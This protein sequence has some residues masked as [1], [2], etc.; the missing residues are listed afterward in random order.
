MDTILPQSFVLL[1]GEHRTLT[2]L[3]ELFTRSSV[4]LLAFLLLQKIAGKQLNSSSRHLFWLFCFAGLALLPLLPGLTSTLPAV[5]TGNITFIQVPIST[6]AVEQATNRNPYTGLAALLL[7]LTPVTVLL[8]R[9]A[10]A[11]WQL[12]R[13]PRQSQ[14]VQNRDTLTLFE[15]LRQ[16]QG[17]TRKVRLVFSHRLSS[18]VSFGLL[19]PYVVLPHKAEQ[20]SPSMLSDVLTHELAHIRRFDWLTML[21][22]RLT[23]AFYW[24]NPLVWLA[25]K[26]ID[27]SAEL[28]CDA[29]VLRSGR[30]ECGYAQTLVNIARIG[31]PGKATPDRPLRLTQSMLDRSTL[32]FRITHILEDK[33]MTQ[34]ISKQRLIATSFATGLL[35]LSLLLVLAPGQSL[36]A[37]NQ[38]DADLYP[39][40]TGIPLYPAEAAE[41]GIEGWVQVKFDINESGMVDPASIDIVEAEPA[42]LFNDAAVEALADFRFSPRVRDGQAVRVAGVQYVFRFNPDDTRQ[43]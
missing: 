12:Y 18:P 31:K 4:L 41:Q 40:N 23:S 11:L 43:E 6:T 26:R 7:Y 13:L 34:S 27:D 20:W 28:C 16:S 32:L 36:N 29:A 2:L 38:A 42:T 10:L 9:H 25:Q 33:T 22:I 19:S 39:L 15:S 8:S 5:L 17:I 24:F 35:S 37:Q 1:L 14:R 21:F 30:N 3:F